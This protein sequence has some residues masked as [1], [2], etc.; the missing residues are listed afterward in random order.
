MN[1]KKITVPSLETVCGGR[2]LNIPTETD[3]LLYEMKSMIS[4]KNNENMICN[5]ALCKR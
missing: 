4:T 5:V 2:L 3:T 1:T